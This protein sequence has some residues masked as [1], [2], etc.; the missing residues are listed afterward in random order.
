[1]NW[2]KRIH[3]IE[4]KGYRR[5]QV[6][7]H[8]NSVSSVGGERL[9]IK[10]D[11][12]IMMMFNKGMKTVAYCFKNYS[13]CS[14]ATIESESHH[15]PSISLIITRPQVKTAQNRKKAALV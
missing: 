2:Q 15:V 6:K 14:Q 12:I 8:T 9:R 7:D 1:M 11:L 10:T 5:R 3:A 13:L 4:L